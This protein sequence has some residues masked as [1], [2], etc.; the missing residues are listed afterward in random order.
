MSPH[1]WLN[2]NDMGLET[3]FLFS[4]QFFFSFFFFFFL[5]LLLSSIKYIYFLFQSLEDLLT[6]GTYFFLLLFYFSFLSFFSW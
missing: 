1:E 3:V 6:D 2:R 5:V 4:F